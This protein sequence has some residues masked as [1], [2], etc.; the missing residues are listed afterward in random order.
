[1]KNITLICLLLFI[2][3][4]FFACKQDIPAP[5]PTPTPA[6]VPTPTPA[7]PPTPTP[8]QTPALS[9]GPT[10]T[11]S[12]S[13]EQFNTS[14]SIETSK[15]V[16]NEEV[17]IDIKII[18]PLLGLG[19]FDI[20]I[21]VD[22]D[23]VAQIVDVEFADFGAIELVEQTNKFIHARGVDTNEIISPGSEEALLATLILKGQNPGTSKIS[24]VILA[25]I[26][27]SYHSIEAEIRSG[28][29]EVNSR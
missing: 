22:D 29:I 7:P 12:F 17:T 13:S 11:P 20:E 5:V 24:C 10:P 4:S 23:E 6:P 27:D 25:M 21:S 3:A 15:I 14:I 9:P 16:V 19:G 2:F 18:K 28:N 8:T 26:D 1:M